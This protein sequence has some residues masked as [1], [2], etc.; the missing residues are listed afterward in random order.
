MKPK[1]AV[2]ALAV[3]L[4]TAVSV[5]AA[6]IT[7]KYTGHGFNILATGPYTNDMFV[8]ALVTLAV[9][10]AP[11]MG[12]DI[13]SPTAF[14]ITDGVQTI[15]NLNATSTFF[16]FA[17]D[18]AGQITTWEI[19]ADRDL[20]GGIHTFNLPD[21]TGGF[22]TDEAS[23]GNEGFAY[24]IDNPGV[25]AGIA[26]PDAASTLSLLSLSLTALGVAAWGL[27]PTAA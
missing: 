7:Y 10:L 21:D 18:P 1:S 2:L 14:T 15:T 23:L 20:V 24:N 6:P 17:T 26:V 19:V 4:L 16:F 13:V 5:Q 8:T 27:K 11:N 25:W 9:P 3:G 12:L 22:I